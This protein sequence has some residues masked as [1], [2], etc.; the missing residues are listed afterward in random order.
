MSDPVELTE[1]SAGTPLADSL[2]AQ[3]SPG[4]RIVVVLSARWAPPCKALK[5]AVQMEE[6]GER[7]RKHAAESIQKALEQARQKREGGPSAPADP[8]H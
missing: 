5:D 2:K 3:A 7:A 8:G 1:L 4:T 6:V